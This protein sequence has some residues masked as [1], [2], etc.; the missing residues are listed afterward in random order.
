M[1]T[2]I[3]NVASFVASIRGLLASPTSGF[4]AEQL[5]YITAFVERVEKYEA[6]TASGVAVAWDE[7]VSAQAKAACEARNYGGGLKDSAARATLRDLVDATCDVAFA[8]RVHD[9]AYHEAP[10]LD[11]GSWFSSR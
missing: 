1:S 9:A 2:N 8:E 10:L 5:P 4:V 11:A 3:V 7:C 6:L